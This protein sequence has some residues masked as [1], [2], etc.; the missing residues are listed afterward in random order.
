VT[1]FLGQLESQ[2]TRAPERLVASHLWHLDLDQRRHLMRATAWPVR[3]VA[4]PLHPFPLVASQPWMDRLPAHL[5]VPRHLRHSASVAEDRHDR[6][7]PLLAQPLHARECQASAESRVKDQPKLCQAS[8]EAVLS[9]ISRIRTFP[10]SGRRDSNPRP[11]TWKA[12]AL[13]AELLPHRA[14]F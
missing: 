7:V 11:P 2:P 14:V 9:G 5:S 3:P 13:P 10:E 6:L 12:G 8:A 4:H 1:P